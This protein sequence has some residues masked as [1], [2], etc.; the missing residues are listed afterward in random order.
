MPYIQKVNKILTERKVQNDGRNEYGSGYAYM[1]TIDN[2][3]M[4]AAD[5]R[6]SA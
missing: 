1:E 6:Q 4:V 5:S 2:R 3:Q